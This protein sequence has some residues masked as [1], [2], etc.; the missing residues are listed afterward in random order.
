MP[1]AINWS[2]AAPAASSN[3]ATESKSKSPRWTR[4]NGR[5]TSASRKPRQAALRLA[6]LAPL[7]AREN[8]WTSKTAT[9]L[10]T[11]APAS[12]A[13]QIAAA[14]VVGV[15]WVLLDSAAEVQHHQVHSALTN[16]EK[17]ERIRALLIEQEPA[18]VSLYA[19][20]A[21]SLGFKVLAQSA[22]ARM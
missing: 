13:N 14:G 4:S 9:E 6:H 20:T 7:R 16:P 11:N 17:H 18:R 22:Q 2:D 5:S 15:D 19:P 8:R 10:P 21:D 3:S 12:R 1:S